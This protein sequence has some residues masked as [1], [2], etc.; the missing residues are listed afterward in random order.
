MMMNQSQCLNAGSL[1]SVT[2]STYKTINDLPLKAIFYNPDCQKNTNSRPAIAFFH[3]GGWAYGKPEEF[4]DIAAHYAERGI[5]C[6][7]IDYRLCIN[8]D[9]S[10]P[11]P[12]ITPVECTKDARSALRWIRQHAQEFQIDPGKIAAFGQSAGGQLA[13]ST[14]LCD[15]IDNDGDP[16]EVS[17]EADLLVLYSSNL[18]TI[19]P[20][21]D[22]LMGERRTE[23][24][25]I[26]PY[27]CLKRGLPPT[28]EFHG[29]EDEQ[30]PF[31]TVDFF[32]QKAITLGNPIERITLPGRT[33]YL[34]KHQD[35]YAHYID[36]GILEQTDV[37]LQ[38]HGFL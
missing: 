12:N 13:L 27:H 15:G 17:P 37:F 35:R 36:E 34:G 9:G 29:T 19:E 38:K 6:F 3:G 32:M 5:V 21:A 30:V 4:A 31:Y 28:L 18:N 26:S 11:N 10:I 2:E 16:M 22:Y 25:S 1:Y 20:W 33:H 14:V 24:W 8:P 23:I 7:L